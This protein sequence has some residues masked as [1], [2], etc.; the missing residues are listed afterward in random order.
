M[1]TD[2]FLQRPPVHPTIYAYSLVGVD[3]HK[4]YLKV[5]FTERDVDTRVREQLHTSGLPYQI[6]LRESAMR[7][8][9]SCFTDHDVHAILRKR[10]FLQLNVGGDRNEWFRCCVNDVMSAIVTL[11]TGTANEENRT[12]TFKMRPEQERAVTKTAEYFKTARKEDKYARAKA[13]I[14]A[15]YHENK[16]RYGYRRITDELHNRKIYLNHKTVQR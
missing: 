6:H 3:S 9:G 12:Q 2:F 11:R 5:G 8:D 14:T 15:I 16:G 10:G 4:G 7:A 1:A 13:E